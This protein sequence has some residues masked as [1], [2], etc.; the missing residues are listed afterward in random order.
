[1]V[2]ITEYLKI[3]LD[4]RDLDKAQAAALQDSIFTGEVPEA[5]IA[6]FLTAMA[7]KGQTPT[8]VAGLAESM[9]SHAVRVPVEAGPLVDTCG[10]GGG[11][12]KTCN[13]STAAALVAAGAGI[14]VAKHGNRGI[15]SGCGSAD[16]L[17]A[18]GVKIDADPEAIARCIAEAGVGFMFAPR[19]HPATR[20]VQ[21]V[22][23]ALGF[24]TVF[25]ILGPLSNPAHVQA[26]VLGVADEKLMPMMIE[27]LRQ[28][29]IQRAMVVHSDGLDEV[30]TFGPTQI[31]ELRDDQVQI[32][33]FEPAQL[34]ITPPALTEL[35]VTDARDSAASL[36][37]V[38]AGEDRGP[39]RDIIALNAAASIQVGGRAESWE[40]GWAAARDSIDSGKALAALEAMVKVSN[41]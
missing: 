37:R 34:G 2:T 32:T 21:P 29:G 8:E 41:S 13:V 40:E 24:R 4:G 3:M 36:K 15:T 35:Q 19:F 1:M 12:Y 27:A 23:K 31:A 25:N 14:R 5:Q 30:S 33:T 6:A 22:R 9:R 18:L 16:V 26:Q 20:Y 10:T 38:L 7:A 17:E 28:L 39:K 11:K